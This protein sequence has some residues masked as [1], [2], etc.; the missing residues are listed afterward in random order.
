MP[1]PVVG[2]QGPDA[3]AM[4]GIE[5]PAMEDKTASVKHQLKVAGEKTQLVGQRMSDEAIMAKHA[6]EAAEGRFI[7]TARQMTLE[8]GSSLERMKLLGTLDH[9]VKQ[10]GMPIGRKALAKLA[11]VLGREGLLEEKHAKSAI[12]YFMAKEADC[13]AP[14]ELI[15]SWLPAR[16]VNGNHPLYIT[17]KTFHEHKDRFADYAA[18]SK[19][20]QDK[21]DIVRQ[22]VRAL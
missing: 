3:Y 20:V 8:G 13:K 6:T 15:S 10:A 7:K 17:L 2:D 16:V 5:R 22:K 14:Q 9:F 19:L 12:D 11:Y 21:L 1:D 4:W 18:K